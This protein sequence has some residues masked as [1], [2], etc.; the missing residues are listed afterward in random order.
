MT[1]PP[2]KQLNKTKNMDIV[3]IDSEE[4]ALITGQIYGYLSAMDKAHLTLYPAEWYVAPSQ[5]RE[6]KPRLRGHG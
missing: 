4:M 2:P 1:T 3:T 6:L 5:V